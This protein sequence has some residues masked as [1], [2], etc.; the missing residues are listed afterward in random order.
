MNHTVVYPSLKDAADQAS[1]KAQRNFLCLNVALLTILASTAL[2][3]GWTP[4]CEETQRIIAIAI[5]ILMFVALA[6]TTMLRL[7]KFDDRWFRCRALAENMKSAVWFFVMC[8]RALIPSSENDYL[9]E[10]AELQKRLVPVTKEVALCDEGG[11]LVTTW[12]KETQNLPLDQ[13][14]T[15]Y[16]QN[17]I[18]D[19]MV[20]YF[21]KSKFNTAREKNWFLAIFIS[22]FIAVA[23]AAL[24]A[25]RLWEI[26]VVAGMAAM[27]AGFIAWMQ[28]KRFSDLGVS[29]SIAANDLRRIAAERENVVTEEDAQI[30]VKEIEAAVSREHSMWLARRID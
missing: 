29:Y 11:P 12:M 26:N 6:T 20:W 7:G 5:A 22:E 18:E 1:D 16:R 28:T 2:I 9:K 15:I 17:R 13:K 14:L 24:Q 30:F 10:V 3:S 23:Y 21:K 25:W 8:P 4:A 27:S 19:Q